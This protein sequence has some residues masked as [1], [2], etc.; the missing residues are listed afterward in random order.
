MIALIFAS[1][2]AVFRHPGDFIPPEESGRLTL[3]LDLPATTP[4]AMAEAR[5]SLGGTP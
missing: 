3:S 5:R 1:V 2:V 4:P